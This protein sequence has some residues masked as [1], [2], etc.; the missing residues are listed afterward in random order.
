M[1]A[2]KNYRL[3][4]EDVARLS[5]VSR[6]TV[7]R[8]INNHPNVSQEVRQR[9]L[10]VIQETG[11]L[12]HL[13]ARSLASQRSRIL[14]LVFPRSVA[15]FFADPYFPRFTQGVAQACNQ[16]DYTLSLFIFYSPEDERKLFPRISHRGHLDGV[17]VQATTA[18]DP[19][20][21]TIRNG[22]I[23]CVF[24]GRAPNSKGFSFVDVDNETGAY[25]AVSHLLQLG[26]KRIATITGPLDQTAG[27]D[28]KQGYIK[29]LQD[30]GRIVENELIASGDFSRISGYNAARAL[31]PQSPDAIFVASD[32]MALGA[33]QAIQEEGLKVPDD[34]A[35]VGFDDL[36]PAR[37]SSPPLS[38]IRQPIMRL[39]VKAVEMLLDI[40]E[41][42]NQSPQRMI[43]DTELVIRESCG[44]N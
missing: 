18:N 5:E 35:I 40:I 4:L 31:L 1:G 42:G 3:T 41:S 24:A 17:I 19:I 32:V 23:P 27:M 37:S 43:F 9:V 39:G 22:S 12:P 29:A 28:R 15:A 36:P 2:E 21:S 20:F 16:N 26:R 13:A 8:V 11:Y 7:S 34:I 10:K 14:G 6:S 44:S 30:R 25:T 33:L 38:T